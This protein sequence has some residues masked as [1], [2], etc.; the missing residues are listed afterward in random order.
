[1][2][3][4]TAL[5]LFAAALVG[6]SL[7][8]SPAMAQP[9]RPAPDS[10][11]IIL[12]GTNGGPSANPH[13][14]E[15]A[16]LLVVNGVPYL[17]DAGAGVSHQ[18]ALAGFPPPRVHHIFI[19][20]H[21]GDHNGG[22]V[23][24]MSLDWW[25]IA[26]RTPKAPPVEIYGPPA[27]KFL[28]KTGLQY[29]SVFV[30]IFRAGMPALET[31]DGMFVAHDIEHGGLVYQDRNVKV[32]AVE[33]THYYFKSGSPETGQDKSYSY[34]FDT[35]HGS[36]VFTGDTGPSEAVT[37]L[38]RGADVLV[39]EVNALHEPASADAD[40]STPPKG[41]RAQLAY[42]MVH[43]HLSPEEVGKMAAAA[44]V[45]TVLLTHFVPGTVTGDMSRFTAGV[46]KYFPGT[47]I[48]GQDL[49]EYDLAGNA[50]NK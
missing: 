41:L 10:T 29:L 38:A 33:N 11:R 24:L 14:S 7:A 23:A 27:T 9:T 20:H 43:E 3:A 16:N 39:S 2:S 50:A 32:T 47:V 40:V 42:H 28:V 35:P 46:K 1:M 22:L 19:T 8:L 25:G 13:R 36:V 44:H 6:A 15:P 48:A 12:L 31:A 30:R 18:L 21:H 49:F 34:R 37:K 5:R 45:K 26:A 17:I 4:K